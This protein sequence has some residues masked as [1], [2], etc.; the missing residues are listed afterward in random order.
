VKW[1]ETLFQRLASAVGRA[2]LPAPMSTVSPQTP[3]TRTY[4]KEG[5]DHLYA[6]YADRI[7]Q[8]K[9][10]ALIYAIAV[11]ETHL[12]ARGNVQ[13]VTFMRAPAQAPEVSSAIVQLIENASPFPLPGRLGA[14]TYVDTWLWDESGKFQLDTLTEG[15]RSH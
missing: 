4:R 5:A 1:L 14:H 11:V 3:A 15:Q 7:Y 9:I 8:G 10:P 2:G 13:Q 12:D 6:R